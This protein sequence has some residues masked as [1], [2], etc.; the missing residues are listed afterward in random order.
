MI[1]KKQTYRKPDFICIGLPKTATT[2]L[3]RVMKFHLQV[4]MTPVKEISYFA[5]QGFKYSKGFWPM[6]F[7]R[8]WYNKKKRATLREAIYLNLRSLVRT[9]GFYNA[10]WYIRFLFFPQNDKWYSRLF[11]RDTNRISGDISP[12]YS[13]L[14]SED[15]EKI[16]RN[17]PEVKIL[18][19]LR[20]PVDRA[21]SH[22][23]MDIGMQGTIPLNVKSEEVHK[24]IDNILHYTPLVNRWK[25]Y[26]PGQR[27]KIFYYDDLV[28]DT[29]DFYNN[30]CD[31]LNIDPQNNSAEILSS[32]SK[33]VHAG[34][35]VQM[36]EEF[37]IR[38]SRAYEHD[39]TD[40]LSI[41]NH[42][43]I[44]KWLERCRKNVESV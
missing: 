7:H 6:L 40:L 21:W 44:K 34:I 18:L 28:A 14:K 1:K 41:E 23:K 3:Y 11:R 27:L 38:L 25:Q 16:S 10:C 31:F 36:P 33:K 39:L 2:W 5:S 12:V 4:D 15:V 35:Q 43:H 19:F 42:K 37:T 13:F 9:A 26:F 20:D 24:A 30:V 29:T 17:F 22:I 8:D 32:L